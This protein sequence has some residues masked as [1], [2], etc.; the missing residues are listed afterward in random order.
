[1]YKYS[2]PTPQK[3][4]K[5]PLFYRPI[6]RLT[7]LFST[8]P[9]IL[10]IHKKSLQIIPKQSQPH[11][12]TL[13]NTLKTLYFNYL[14]TTTNPLKTSLQNTHPRYPFRTHFTHS[15]SVSFVNSKST[16]HQTLNFIYSNPSTNNPIQYT[17]HKNI[18]LT[19]HTYQTQ[20]KK[21]MKLIISHPQSL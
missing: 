2:H 7:P 12:P 21:E 18:P 19:T 6:I 17:I 16:F 8:L 3:P 5:I 4:T 10:Y 14:S 9:T 1:M 11:Q 13:S 20:N 15:T